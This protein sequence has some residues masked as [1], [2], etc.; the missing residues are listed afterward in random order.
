MKDSIRKTHLAS[1]TDRFVRGQMDRRSFLRAASIL[2]LGAGAL[3]MGFGRR[4]FY[5]ISQASAQEQE[6]KPSA[7]ITKWLSDVGKPFAGTTLRLA[8]ESTPPSNAIATQLKQYFEEATGIKVEIEVLPLEQVLQKLTLDVASSLGTYDLYYIDQSWAASFSQ[9]VFDPREQLKNA[10]LAMPNY[11]IDD[12]LKPLVDGIAMYE[13]RMVGVPYDI[14]I[15]IMQYRKD[16]WDELKLPPP[17]TLD[18]LLKASAAITDA[19]GPNMYGTSGQM[20]SGH[21]SLECDW[22][23]W[24]WGHGGS[25]FGPDGKFTGNDE[26]GLAAMA[27]WDKLKKTMPPGVDGWTWDGEGQSVGQGVAA[28]MLSWGEFFP[29]FD[30][31]KASKV[32]GLMEAMV[33]PKPAATLR[34]VEQT[35][36]GEIPGVGHQGGSSLAVSK[37]SKSPDAAWIFMQ[38]ATSADTQ[39]LITVLGGGTGPTR[40][41]VY[42]DPRV[43]ANARVGA[44]TTRHLPVV[45]DTIANYMGSEPD[46][47]AW[48]ELSSDTIP[49]ALGKYFAGQS[50][51]AKESLDALKTQVDDLVAKG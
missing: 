4:P 8:T 40:T 42:D 34:T 30:D 29:F 1:V 41:S 36:F 31:P 39:A 46:L 16:V 26:A 35:G 27:Y 38:W 32:S 24:L 23:A 7:E 5:G 3:G 17:A 11:N 33:P 25:I 20:K 18:D 47:P 13:D 43:L 6:L 2:G 51:S 48:A 14:P 45:R 21:Y 50:G 44:G 37:Y 10:D 22:T 28:S 12:F 49:V 9:D 19:K 15:F